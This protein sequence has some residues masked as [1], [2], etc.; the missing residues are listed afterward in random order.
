MWPDL[1]QDANPVVRAQMNDLDIVLPYVHGRKVCV[2]AGGN[3]GVWPKYLSTLF[4]TVY[5]F[6][7]DPENFNCL[8][9][10]VPEHNV[11]KFNA[12]LG[13]VHEMIKVGSPDKWHDNNCGAY[14]VLGEG[15]IPVM[16]IDDLVLPAC[17]LMYLDIEG[18]EYFAV[19]G[20]LRTIDEHKPVIAYEDKDLPENYGIERE[21]LAKY[22]IK[23][24]GYELVERI[25]RDIVL[26]H[27]SQL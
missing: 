27:R 21:Q 26:V 25:H 7:P 20:A 17:D 15:R 1:D 6:E 18:Y 9:F 8:A 22:L 19:Q 24:H 16:R 3:V 10:N 11:V 12:A 23:A 2:Q 5:T 13:A 14:Q 4:E